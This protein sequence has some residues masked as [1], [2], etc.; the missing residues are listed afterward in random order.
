MEDYEMEKKSEDERAASDGCSYC[1]F[2]GSQGLSGHCG[3]CPNKGSWP[4]HSNG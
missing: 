3:N 1:E 4:V 2:G